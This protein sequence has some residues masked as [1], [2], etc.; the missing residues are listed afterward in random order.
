MITVRYFI[1]Q[2]AQKALAAVG[3]PAHRERIIIVKEKPPAELLAIVHLDLDGDSELD[4]R[5]AG[6]WKIQEQTGFVSRAAS[7][8]YELIVRVQQNYHWQES[9]RAN[10]QL[11][12][13]ALLTLDALLDWVRQDLAQKENLAAQETFRET[14]KAEAEALLPA[15]LAESIAETEKD[16]EEAQK[17]EIT[18]LHIQVSDLEA[19]IDELT[20]GDVSEEAP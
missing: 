7:N 9:V 14:A 16:Y 2:E 15:K 17:K 10:S 13:P 8:R 4:L 1:N 5:F 6:P 11:L 18:D 20:H 12:F 3:E 19:R